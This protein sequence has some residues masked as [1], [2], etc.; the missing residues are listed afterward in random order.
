MAQ[1]TQN[2]RGRVRAPRVH[3]KYDIETEGAIMMESLPFVLGVV[4]DFSGDRHREQ[5]PA[6]K[7]QPFRERDFKDVN[8]VNFDDVLKDVA[9][10]LR[11]TVEN[12]LQGGSDSKLNVDLAFANMKDFEPEAIAQQFEPTRQLLELRQKMVK[13]FTRLEGHRDTGKL[14]QQLIE[15][16]AP[17]A[18]AEAKMEDISTTE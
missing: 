17:A 6:K 18:E 12:K 13:L 2:V 14:L 5:D 11:L 8:M 3:I 9:P 16:L 4:G 7:L 15:R 1:S 10:T